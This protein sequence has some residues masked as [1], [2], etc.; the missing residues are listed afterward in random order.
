MPLYLPMCEASL[1]LMASHC[2][3]SGCFVVES[4]ESSSAPLSN[5]RIVTVGIIPPDRRWPEIAQSVQAVVVEQR[6]PGRYIGPAFTAGHRNADDEPLQES[7]VSRRRR[8]LADWL[9]LDEAEDRNRQ[10]RDVGAPRPMRSTVCG[11]PL[12][13]SQPERPSCRPARRASRNTCPSSRTSRTARPVPAARRRG[14][15]S[16]CPAAASTVVF[17]ILA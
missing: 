1:R 15:P 6:L 16:G 2:W 13:V 14:C 8:H 11:L 17:M 12:K 10:M 9:R 5:V 3:S 7:V 4:D